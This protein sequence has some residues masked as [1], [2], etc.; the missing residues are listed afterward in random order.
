MTPSESAEQKRL[1]QQSER[2]NLRTTQEDLQQRTRTFARLN[3]PSVSLA[4]GARSRA[5]P[6]R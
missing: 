3:S 6:L 2:E 5:L 4:T 1:R